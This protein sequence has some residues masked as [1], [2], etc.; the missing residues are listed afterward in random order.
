MFW[1]SP[2]GL[3]KSWSKVNFDFVS[4]ILEKMQLLKFTYCFFYPKEKVLL[5]V[6]AAPLGAKLSLWNTGKKKV[7]TKITNY[8]QN[9]SNKPAP[10]VS[11]SFASWPI[12]LPTKSLTISRH[13]WLNSALHRFGFFSIGAC[14]LRRSI[15]DW[16][17]VFG[18]V[19]SLRAVTRRISAPHQSVA[20][21]WWARRGALLLL[22]ISSHF[23]PVWT[24]NNN[25]FR[26][27][28]AT[29]PTVS[30]R[31]I[32][33]KEADQ[34]FVPIKNCAFL[35]L[36]SHLTPQRVCGRPGTPLPGCSSPGKG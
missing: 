34:T 10:H 20:G 14:V 22:T 7:R 30:T 29:F 28:S 11:P 6:E 33:I 36:S 15:S 2:L 13:L 16:L 17:E 18:S 4:R 5:L 31:T 3:S 24:N 32:Q 21:T 12:F 8:P 1:W 25:I 19:Q 9:F 35:P 26:G 23:Q 27:L